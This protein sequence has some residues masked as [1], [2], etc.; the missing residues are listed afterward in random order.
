[1]TNLLNGGFAGAI[2]PVNPNRQQV[3][4][5][6]CYPSLNALPERTDLAIVVVPA[7]AVSQVIADCGRVGIQRATV[8]SSGFAEA[9]ADGIQRQ[10]DLLA[11]ARK[12][13]VRLAGPNCL[14][15]V[16]YVNQFSGT[17]S[18][19]DW[20]TPQPRRGRIAIISQSGALVSVPA[21]SSAAERGVGIGHIVSVGNQ[22]DLGIVDF[23]EYF[24]DEDKDIDAVS[25]YMESL[26]PG[27]GARFLDV[28][29]RAA[30]MGKPILIMRV[31]RTEQG[32]AAVQSHTGALA[33][34]DQVY[35]GCFRQGGVT[36]VDDLDDLWESAESLRVLAVADYAGGVGLV[37]N[38]GGMNS[39]LADA[40]SSAGVRLASIDPITSRTIADS[41][42]GGVA[43]A[44]TNPLD[45]SGAI[46]S[47]KLGV[48][49]DSLARDPNVAA[50]VVGLTTIASG[51]RSLMIA[52]RISD[53]AARSTKPILVVWPSALNG[54]GAAGVES[55][56]AY[57]LASGG[58]PVVRSPRRAATIL[59][60]W[61]TWTERRRSLSSVLKAPSCESEVALT[62][63]QFAD[64]L[65]L[66]RSIGVPSPESLTTSF[67]VD[68][69]L[70][71]ARAIGFP[72][73][74][75]IDAPGL[76]HK[77]DIGAVAVDI[78][79]PEELR[80]EFAKLQANGQ[81]LGS[82]RRLLVQEFT[83]GPLQLAVGFI[84]DDVF[85]AVVMVGV[86]GVNVE[87]TGIA[88]W[89][90][91]PIDRTEAALMLDEICV[92]PALAYTRGVGPLDAQGTID[93]I[94]AIARLS[95]VSRERI[96]EFEVNPLIV[97]KAG[98]GV[99]AVDAL[100]LLNHR[101]EGWR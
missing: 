6:K 69:A 52:D 93:A 66:V 61:R 100:V 4:G 92:G 45:I 37:S 33:G 28:S 23:L 70:D 55:S 57:R 86:G 26:R 54:H 11:I 1:M 81:E 38:S 97:R 76:L 3:F 58:V 34:T 67:D 17:A 77:T 90:C 91:A 84:T 96:R 29:H 89:R 50:T 94:V 80:A 98:A 51:E 20:Q 16:S 75:K 78:R 2:Y 13:S 30:V 79:N 95:E 63:D 65:G 39:V 41:L 74:L 72:V 71:A 53:A 5:R 99:R 18:N 19:I 22:A 15:I 35:A 8:V 48:V 9:G 24:V 68:A 10:S 7:T 44:R 27:E 87:S 21:P 47:D 40:L 25:I 56:G 59:G 14:G 46:G 85:G 31:G 32:R 43:R 42:D 73:A 49:L 64:A 62:G 101:A 88:A 60:W 36:Q 83:P 12:G 82:N